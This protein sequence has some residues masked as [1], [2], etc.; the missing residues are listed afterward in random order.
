MSKQQQLSC[1]ARGNGFIPVA[2]ATYFIDNEPVHTG[3]FEMIGDSL[4]PVHNTDTSKRVRTCVLRE[5]HPDIKGD[6]HYRAIEDV[7][8]PTEAEPRYV[9]IFESYDDRV[10]GSVSMPVTLTCFTPVKVFKV[11]KG[12][13]QYFGAAQR[14]K[15]AA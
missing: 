5:R 12:P 13:D 7:L 15:R 1:V 3:L 2:D 10:K 9:G 4:Q 8:P 11:E 14:R 6:S